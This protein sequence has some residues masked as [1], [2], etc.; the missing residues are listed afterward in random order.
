MTFSGLAEF[1]DKKRT[2]IVEEWK[3][4]A[5]SLTPAATGM[6]AIALRDHA[7]EIL[8]AIVSDMK[9]QQTA[10]ERAEKS[11][12]RGTA[13]RLGNIGSIHAELRIENGFK[14]GQVVASTARSARASCAYGNP[15]AGTPR[16]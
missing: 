13:Q 14:L 5:E 7:D 2:E 6:N 12:G 15:R 1:I 3:V 16:A 9:S 8:T 4:F 11:K 10:V